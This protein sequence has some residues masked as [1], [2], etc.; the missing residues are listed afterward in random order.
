MDD[1]RVY[2]KVKIKSL[3]AEARII[4]VEE[5]RNKDFRARLEFHRKHKVR[6]EA[7]ATLL[8]YAY[9][10]GIPYKK[11]ESDAKHQP[12]WNRVSTMVK[13]YGSGYLDQG[14]LKKWMDA[15]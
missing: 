6:P 11:V 9:I 3:A 8:A 7:R 10:R 13:K 1:E 4:R 15:S 12:D 14:D 2:L 5:K